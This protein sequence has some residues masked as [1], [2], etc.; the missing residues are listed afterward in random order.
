MSSVSLESPFNPDRK[1]LQ[2]SLPREKRVRA[3]RGLKESVPCAHTLG[4]DAQHP[5]VSQQ[6]KRPCSSVG[7]AVDS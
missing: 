7:R 6:L 4:S 3:K 1:L 5:S 2:F